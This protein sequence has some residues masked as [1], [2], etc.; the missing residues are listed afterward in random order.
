MGGLT[1]DWIQLASALGAMQGALLI[2]ALVAQKR[3]RTANRLLAVLMATFTIYLAQGVYYATGLYRAFPHLTGIAT[4]TPWTFGPL[5]YLYARAASDRAWRFTAREWLHFVP[6]AVALALAV[7]TFALSAAAKLAM[8]DQILTGARRPPL[9][10]LDPLKYLSGIAYSAATVRYLRDHRRRVLDSYSN[11]AR[12]NLTWLLWLAGGAAA[13]WVLATVVRVGDTALPVRDAHVSLAI[14]LLVYAT[15]YMGLRQPEVFRYATAEWPLPH[16]AVATTASPA[17]AVAVAAP[18]E[19]APP[20]ARYERS[21]LD[22]AEA[23][24]AVRV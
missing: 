3:N 12:A 8:L 7:P 20:R 13:I 1:L 2:G 16:P 21:G 10:W 22:D 23:A 4:F 6:V 18:A 11:T 24:A 9:A 17:A 14:A 5:V 19:P 15:G